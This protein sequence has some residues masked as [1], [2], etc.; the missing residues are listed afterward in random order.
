MSPALYMRCGYAL[1]GDAWPVQMGL[2]LELDPRTA[3]LIAASARAGADD[4]IAPGL[5]EELR[6]TLFERLDDI[7]ALIRELDAVTNSTLV[8]T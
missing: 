4:P 3:E 2:L 1:F 8:G 6:E 5:A 7:C